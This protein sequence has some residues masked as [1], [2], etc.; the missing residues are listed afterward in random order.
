MNNMKRLYII[1]PIVAF[2]FC[3]INSCS[4]FED[5]TTY[6]ESTKSVVG[7]W[8][9]IHAFR[10]DVEIT[11]LM[12]FSEFRISFKE[13]G[14]YTIENYLPFIVSLNGVYE[15]DDP[16]YPLQIF[17]TQ[18]DNSEKVKTLLNF[19]IVDADRRIELTFSPGCASNTYTYVLDR[20]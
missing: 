15:L 8:K 14:T 11:D 17:F 1:K 12:D 9:I 6:T 18:S 13:D 3:F 4:Y 7:D 16:Q 2:C 5:D 20:D 10:N 19:P